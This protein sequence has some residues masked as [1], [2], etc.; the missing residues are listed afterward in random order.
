LPKALFEELGKCLQ[1]FKGLKHPPNGDWVGLLRYTSDMPKCRERLGSIDE[2]RDFST[3]RKGP[4]Q[5]ALNFKT[6]ETKD[7]IFKPL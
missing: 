1:R 6:E 4:F 5:E 3:E 2:F 7:E